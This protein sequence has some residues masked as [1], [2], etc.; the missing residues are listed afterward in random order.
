[1]ADGSERVQLAAPMV[2]IRQDFSIVFFITHNTV[3]EHISPFLYNYNLTFWF[4]L[5][6]DLY[7]LPGAVTLS[8]HTVSIVVVLL[9]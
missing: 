2:R 9:Y 1:M 4:F 7:L 5:L 8:L 6:V 3:N